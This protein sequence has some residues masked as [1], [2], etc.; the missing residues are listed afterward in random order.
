M[1]PTAH[2]TGQ[3][4]S[5]SRAQPLD[6]L[7]TSNDFLVALQQPQRIGSE[8]EVLGVR[9]RIVEQI[10]YEEYVTTWAFKGFPS[11]AISINPRVYYR[12]VMLSEVGS[13]FRRHSETEVRG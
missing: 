13:K 7:G 3:N 4:R 12:C 11:E 9:G 8:V 2:T 5:D 10:T 6:I 1:T